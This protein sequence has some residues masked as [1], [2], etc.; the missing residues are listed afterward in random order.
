MN[1]RG[2]S[3]RPQRSPKSSWAWRGKQ[4]GREKETRAGSSGQL[5]GKARGEK[6]RGGRLGGGVRRRESLR[7]QCGARGGK[8]RREPSKERGPYRRASGLLVAR[9]SRRLAAGL[10][11]ARRETSRCA[12]RRTERSFLTASRRGRRAGPGEGWVRRRRRPEW[13]LPP[14]R[15]CGEK[16]PVETP[17]KLARESERVTWR[18]APELAR[19]SWRRQQLRAAAPSP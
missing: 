1:P 5:G 16:S 12:D 9:R 4:K 6:K 19:R 18:Q 14:A 8:R 13:L 15:S 10:G 2:S 17:V 11:H 3:R 7:Q